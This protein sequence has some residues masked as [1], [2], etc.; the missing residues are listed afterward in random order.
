MAGR[1]PLDGAIAL[2]IQ[3]AMPVPAS[4]PKK[5]QAAALR[6]EVRPAGRPDLD[7]LLKAI[8][9]GMNGVVFRDDSQVVEVTA[10][11]IYGADPQARVVIQPMETR[12]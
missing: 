4:W 6:G 11:K 2:D 3:I 8:S 10:R 7:N 1:A 5:R 9:D 12:R